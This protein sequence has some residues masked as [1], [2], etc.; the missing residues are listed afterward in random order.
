MSSEVS[1]ERVHLPDG[2][3]FHIVR[4]GKTGAPILFLHG[5]IDSWRSFERMFPALSDRF[6][7]WAPDQ[8]GHGETEATEHYGVAD[9]TADAIALTELLSNQPVHLVGHSLGAIIAQRVADSR[10]DLLRSMTLIGGTV[11]ARGNPALSTLAE[12]LK[13]LNDPIPYAFAYDFQKSTAFQPLPESV[14][15]GYVQESMKVRS[16]AWKG[17][18]QGLISDPYESVKPTPAVPTLIIWGEHDELFPLPDQEVLRARLP[19]ARV[20]NFPS[21]GHAPQWEDP[22]GVAQAVLAFIDECAP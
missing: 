21:N 5:Y 13:D 15:K 8:R 6:V 20:V 19:H 14:L 11:T 1:H 22:V 7:L 17:A 9:F 16:P 18:L 12:G 2:R 10:P 4:A 3:A